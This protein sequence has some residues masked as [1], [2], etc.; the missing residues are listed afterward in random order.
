MS[1]ACPGCGAAFAPSDGPVHR[2]IGASPACWALY[3]EVL[4]AEYSDYAF[5]RAAHHMT[6]DAYA[7]QHAGEPSP[8]ATRS[9]ATHLLALHALFEGEGTAD[10]MLVARRAAAKRKDRFVWLDPPPGHAPITVK[11]VAGAPDAATHG[12]RVAAWADAVWQHAAPHHDT[13]RRWSA[14]T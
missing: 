7:V 1:E 12:A 5:F 10:A 6:V 11:D 3:N 4:A 9:V 14:A 13:I 2:Y 8:Q